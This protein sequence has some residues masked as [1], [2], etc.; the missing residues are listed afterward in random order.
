LKESILRILVLNEMLIEMDEPLVL[1]KGDRV[2]VELAYDLEESIEYG[3]DV[4]TQ[5]KTID[6][7]TYQPGAADD[8]V[9]TEGQA[10]YTC[11]TIPT[12]TAT[13]SKE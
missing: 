6:G 8:C 9:G 2:T 1:S 11:V 7:G 4:D 10:D 3:A 5:E 12:M 13:F